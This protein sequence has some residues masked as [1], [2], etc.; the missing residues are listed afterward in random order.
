MGTAPA[1]PETLKGPPMSRAT[2]ISL[3]VYF[4][5]AS[6]LIVYLLI[7]IWPAGTAEV[8]SS[9][10]AVSTEE[11]SASPS[12]PSKQRGGL[13]TWT[14]ALGDEARLLL[15]VALVGALGA[16]VHA[17]QSFVTFVG[18]RQ[19]VGSWLWWYLLRPFIGLALAEILY[20]AVRGGFFSVGTDTRAINHFGIA[21]LAG[22]TGMFSKEATDKLHE[23][24]KN[25]FRTE[26]EVPRKEKLEDS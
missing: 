2:V 20:L 13:S 1:Q 23:L 18:N 16:Y 11:Q 9:P 19:I 24:F 4:I 6:V 15:I 26:K 21:A 7:V 17:A 5:A 3:G 8:S 22:L 12:E 10:V 25:F 14:R